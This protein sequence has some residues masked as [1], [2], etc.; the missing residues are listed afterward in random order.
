MFPVFPPGARPACS[1]CI[2]FAPTKTGECEHA[3]ASI[4]VDAAVHHALLF[5]AY[6]RK[7]KH[8]FEFDVLKLFVAQRFARAKNRKMTSA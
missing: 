5:N 7:R 4:Q 2:A 6:R 8:F 3:L 1:L